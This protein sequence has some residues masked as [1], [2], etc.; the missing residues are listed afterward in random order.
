MS[1]TI[2][3]SRAGDREQLRKLLL[4]NT[5]QLIGT[6]N[7]I[8]EARL[9]WDGQPIL[10]ADA[11]RRPVLLSFETEHSETALLNGLRGVEQLCKAL[12]WAN[13]VYAE[14]QQQKTPRLVV[15]AED[16]P[17]GSS[18]VLNGCPD[19]ILYRYKLLSINSELSLWLERLRASGE[20]QAIPEEASERGATKQL[21][22]AASNDVLPALSEAESAYFQQL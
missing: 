17:P 6:G 7:S 19:L 22:D 21:P 3:T 20:P 14:L 1:V 18:A 11:A 13:Q 12:A 16:F 15:V 8:L 4:D 9:R 10:L 2:E 5:D